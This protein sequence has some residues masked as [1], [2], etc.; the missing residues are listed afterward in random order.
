M[1]SGRRRPVCSQAIGVSPGPP[2]YLLWATAAARTAVLRG[3]EVTLRSEAGR[4][5]SEGAGCRPMPSSSRHGESADAGGGHKRPRHAPTWPGNYGSCLTA[6]GLARSRCVRSS[7]PARNAVFGPDSY[8]RRSGD[9]LMLQAAVASALVT[10][11]N[12]LS[13][14]AAVDSP[15]R[16]RPCSE[17][18]EW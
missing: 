12:R 8:A 1:T 3:A 14:S 7:F 10:L 6:A 16:G 9:Q 18:S 11:W 2:R 13:V 15:R 4:T 5:G 17:W